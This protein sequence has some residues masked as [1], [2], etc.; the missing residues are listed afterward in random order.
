MYA[1]LVIGAATNPIQC[2]RDIAR[3]VTSSSP[4]ISDLSGSGFSTTTSVIIDDTPA[5]WTYVGSNRTADQPTIG[6]GASDA[7]WAVGG[8][9]TKLV[10]SAPCL[11]AAQRPKYAVL[12]HAMTATTTNTSYFFALCGAYDSTELGITTSQGIIFATLA[13]ANTT[14]QLPNL[15]TSGATTIHLIAT[16]RHITLIQ[17]NRGMHGVWETTSTPIHDR[18]LTAPFVQ[19]Y[20][21][22]ASNVTTGAPSTVVNTSAVT[23]ATSGITANIGATVF[24]VTDVNTG[25]FYGAADAT[26]GAKTNLGNL[27]Q[28]RA[29]ARANTIDSLGNPRYQVSPVFFQMSEMGYP[30]QFVTGPVPIYWCKAGLGQTGDSV[31]INGQTY[32]YFHTGAF[33]TSSYG[34]L[35][36]IN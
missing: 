36:K 12:T 7:T 31:N 1:K 20:H 34:V 3:L 26:S 19:Y 23:V 13:T 16:P 5:G 18:L 33:G 4:S 27:I 11:N 28:Y 2:M 6:S 32:Y 15:A 14:F 17:E 10:L 25:V 30:V 35:M 8:T 22:Q 24:G 29:N 21:G 9:L